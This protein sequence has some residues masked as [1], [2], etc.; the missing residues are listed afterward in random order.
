MLS[1]SV[2]EK[3]SD[4]LEFRL[5]ATPTGDRY[6]NTLDDL[7]CRHALE[8]RFSNQDICDKW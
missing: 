1:V 7:L 8:H 2:D 4:R 3:G 5:I 6:P